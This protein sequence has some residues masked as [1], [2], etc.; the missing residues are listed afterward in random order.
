MSNCRPHTKKKRVNT[1]LYVNKK[2]NPQ[3]SPPR[4]LRI[5]RPVSDYI[6]EIS[7]ERKKLTIQK[8]PAIQMVAVKALNS[9]SDIDYYIDGVTKIDGYIDSCF[10]S[11]RT[12]EVYLFIE[13]EFVLLDYAPD[14]K[15]DRVIN[16]PLFI[17]NG[18]GS[19][20]A[21][22]FANHGIDAAF[23]CHGVSEAFIFS[24]NVCAKFNYSPGTVLNI[25]IVCLCFVYL[26]ITWGL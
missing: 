13:K 9:S 18:F 23:G 2:F 8:F 12:N 7:K 10:R 6:D 21:T 11:V 5:L 17:S 25:Q 14:T 22:A 20:I 4:N 26:V 16:G 19:L 1:I 3:S 24:A 15:K